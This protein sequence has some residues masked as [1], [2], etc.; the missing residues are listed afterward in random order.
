MNKILVVDESALFRKFSTYLLGYYGYKII[1]ARSAFDGLNQ[2]RKAQPD[3]IIMDDGLNRQ[4][5][6]SFLKKKNEDI[7]VKDIP[8]IFIADQ[9]SQ[10]RIVELCRIKVRRF[11]LKP[12]KVD[13][14]LDTVS[15]FFK[16]GLFIDRT[17]CQLNLHVN[18]NLILVEIARGFNRT[19]LDLVSWKIKEVL[20]SNSIDNP[21]IMLL[22]S[23]VVVDDQTENILDSLLKSLIA[24]PNNRDDVKILTNDKYVK[25]AVMSNPGMEGIDICNSLIEAID[26]FFGK[27]GLEKLTSNQDMVH[28]IYLATQEDFDTTGII[29]LNFKDEQRVSQE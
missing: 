28:Q 23:D 6:N 2:L 1:T 22:I 11:L 15:S 27:K 19:K 13:Q 24:I 12:L 16:K 20:I 26:A 8:V 18:E 14:F 5:V 7:N 29:D 9:F 17:E 4:S 10:E 3:L 21:K 25:N